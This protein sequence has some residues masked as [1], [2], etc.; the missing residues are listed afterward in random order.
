MACASVGVDRSTHYA[1]LKDDLD[2]A[3]AFAE[4]LPIAAGL[5]EDEA[6][7]RAYHGTLKP[8]NVG[9]K[10]VMVTE[11]SDRLMEVLLKARNRAVFGDR[12]DLQITGK[13]G[14]PLIPLAALDALLHGDDPD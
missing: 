4:A 12:Q 6:F 2:Y 8:M 7:R 1:W 9:G 13:D 11:F 3:K 5:L 10:I 14:S